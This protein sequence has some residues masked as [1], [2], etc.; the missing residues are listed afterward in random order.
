MLDPHNIFGSNSQ[1]SHGIVVGF[2]QLGKIF[3]EDEFLILNLK[4]SELIE[5]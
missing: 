4:V 3:S 5:I 1:I 2:A